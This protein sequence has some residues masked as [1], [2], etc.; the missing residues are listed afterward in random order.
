MAA[1]A[2]P[3]ASLW[4][5]IGVNLALL[6]VLVTVLDVGVFSL[7]TK[8]VLEEA[9]VD[10]AESAAVVVAAEVAAADPEQW[11][12]IVE[13]NSRRGLRGVAVWTV[14]AGEVVGDAGEIDT[15]VK[16]T[17]ATRALYSEI[18]GGDVRVVAP[19]GSGRPVGVVT[20][21]YP[22]SRVERPAWGVVAAHALFSAGVIGL[23]GW[24]L[25]RRN[26]LE[27]LRKIADATARMAAGDFA[28]PV[29]T[30]APTELAQI[31]AALATM[32]GALQGYQARTEEQLAR[33][34]A[35]NRELRLAQD[36]LVRTEKLAGVGRLAAGLAHE[37]GN[38]LAAVRGYVELL[39]ASPDAPEN[40]ELLRRAQLDVERMHRLLRNLLDYARGDEES[41]G[42]VDVEELVAEAARTVQHQVVFR[43]VEIVVGASSVGT[44]RGEPAKLHQVLVNLLLNAAEAGAHK[45]SIGVART[46]GWVGIGVV[47]DG[48]GIPADHLPRLFEPFF[49]T[50]P[51]GQGTGL[52]LATALRI[53]EQHGGRI[54]VESERGRGSR[55]VC[56]LPAAP[57][58]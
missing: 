1:V 6:T 50:R 43:G 34:E 31:A 8:Y 10:L 40:R 49:T 58:G 48:E 36:A 56:W 24:V 39:V 42:A 30:D 26:V 27:P 12:V 32:G 21:R 9:S 47:D 54:E 7:A 2:R 19:V 29:P 45:V 55:F 38:P 17:V 4:V 13:E 35:A 44:L 53:L 57:V 52:G 16:R 46:P 41:V 51:P 37:L 3:R 25:L 15:L 33:L 14:R 11:P 28:A 5:E 20:L 18:Q 23:F 22:L